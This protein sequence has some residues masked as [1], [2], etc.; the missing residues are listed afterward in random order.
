M[1]PNGTPEFQDGKGIE[2]RVLHENSMKK[3]RLGRKKW[4]HLGEVWVFILKTQASNTVGRIIFGRSEH[5]LDVGRW[6]AQYLA[7]HTAEYH[8]RQCLWLRVAR[9]R[10]KSLHTRTIAT[11]TEVG[12]HLEGVVTPGHRTCY[13]NLIAPMPIKVH[14]TPALVERALLNEGMTWEEYGSTG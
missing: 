12:D 13:P 8:A 14:V 1:L 4:A 10:V 7:S 2:F 3:W 9:L 5:M 6:Q 11:L